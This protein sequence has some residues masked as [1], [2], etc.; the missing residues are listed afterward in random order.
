MEHMNT[1][2]KFAPSPYQQAY[3]DWI[4]T[5]EGNV[6]IEAVA[7]SGKTTTIIQGLGRMSGQV[8]LGAYNT[9]MAKELLLRTTSMPGVTAST[10][11]SAGFKALRF[12][13]S[14]KHRLEVDDKKCS[15]IAASIADPARRP[16]LLPI[17]S[18]VVAMVSMAKQRGIGALVSENDYQAWIDMVDQFGLDENLPDEFEDR[19]DKVVKFAQVV[20]ARSNES[21]DTIDYDDMVYLPLKRGL[22]MLQYDWVLID[23]AQDTN[24]TRRALARK[25][26]RPGGRL[27][28]VGDPRQ[29]IFGFTGADN[30]ALDQIA[31]DFGCARLP[32][33]VSYRCPRAVVKHAQQWVNHILPHESAPEG[34][35]SVLGFAEAVAAI[36]PGDAVLCRYNKYIVS[37]CFKLIRNGVAARIEGRSSIGEGLLALAGRWKV[38]TLDALDK[39]LD[40]HLERETK[41]A[42]AKDNEA[43]AERVAD[44]VETLRVLMES[45]RERGLH[46]V[47]GLRAIID[48]MFGD[49]VSSDKIVTLCSVH[50]SKGLEWK[51]VWLLGR[52]E[53][54][55]SKMARKPWQVEQ[56][57]NLVYVAVTRSKSE[58]VE[59][60]G[61]VEAFGSKSAKPV[62]AQ[63]LEAAAA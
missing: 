34:S 11:H 29:A 17:V 5:G 16:D 39:K 45:A 24:P 41:K 53:L 2:A 9:K 44:Q 59:I 57:F 51:K 1:E 20:L 62:V 28:A 23:E 26:L 3:F 27:V 25:M 49:R 38:K 46:S 61:V 43:R 37:L 12:A 58:L 48:G 19:M 50:R 52:A 30:D 14:K 7:G 40:T 60:T 15:K 55:P 56:E 47:D 63:P 4:D 36:K 21:L 54:M 6:I 13:F 31:R 35:V 42:L 10:F 18:T 22:R 33:S 32:L 8:F